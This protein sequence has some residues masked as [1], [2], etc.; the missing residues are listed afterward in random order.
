MLVTSIQTAS[1]EM[2]ANWFMHTWSLLQNDSIDVLI[3]ALRQVR[4]D[5]LHNVL[6]LRVLVGFGV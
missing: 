4:S 6:R 2:S 3:Y 5:S 1:F